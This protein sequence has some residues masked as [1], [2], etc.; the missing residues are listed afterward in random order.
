MSFGVCVTVV[1]IAPVIDLFAFLYF[2]KEN[3]LR[4]V[5]TPVSAPRTISQHRT[6]RLNSINQLIFVMELPCVFFEVGTEFL[7]IIQMNFV[8][9]KVDR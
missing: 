6:R 3:C 2:K 7:S 1:V 4:C 5:N 9:E 8:L